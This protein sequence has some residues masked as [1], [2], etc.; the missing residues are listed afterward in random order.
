M[1][2]KFFTRCNFLWTVGSFN[3]S[4]N[5]SIKEIFTMKSAYFLLLLLLSD[6]V[7][8]KKVTME[9]LS[10]LNSPVLMTEPP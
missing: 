8:N 7:K 5:F 1:S 6:R 9:K 10:Q 4:N 2:T 3:L